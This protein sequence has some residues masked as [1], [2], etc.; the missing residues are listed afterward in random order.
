MEI[1]KHIEAVPFKTTK[2][3]FFFQFFQVYSVIFKCTG[4]VAK[5]NNDCNSDLFFCLLFKVIV[6]L[7][8]ANKVLLF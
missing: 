4:V 5:K 2:T 6:R 8:S 3:N 1:C 7:N